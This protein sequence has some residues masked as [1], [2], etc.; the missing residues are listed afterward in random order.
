VR[1]IQAFQGFMQR[2]L[3][4]EAIDKAKPFQPP[5]FLRVLSR[6]PVLRDV[7]GRIVGLGFGRER[8]RPARPGV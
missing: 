5:L 2:N 3:V 4:A 7:P 6:I 1:L 8:A